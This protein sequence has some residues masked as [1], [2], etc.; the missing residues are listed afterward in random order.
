MSKSLAV[1]VVTCGFLTGPAIADMTNDV[2][3]HWSYH[4]VVRPG[5]CYC[6][7]DNSGTVYEVGPTSSSVHAALAFDWITD[8]FRHETMD[9][10]RLVPHPSYSRK[11]TGLDFF[12]AC[13]FW[14]GHSPGFGIDYGAA[15]WPLY[16]PVGISIAAD[17]SVVTPSSDHYTPYA[18]GD[19]LRQY[20][21]Y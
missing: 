19:Y 4:D 5:V 7:R 20:L 17:T 6:S 8:L 18:D 16:P 2:V 11:R 3:S 9:D 21:G 12:S 14:A 13:L 1:M 15:D 10:G